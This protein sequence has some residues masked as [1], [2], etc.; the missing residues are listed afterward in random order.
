[1]AKHSLLHR[2]DCHASGIAEQYAAAIKDDNEPVFLCAHHLTR[3]AD[4]LDANGWT[5]VIL[6][7]PLVKVP[8]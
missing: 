8:A 4:W 1:M 5:V 6:N 2:A 3:H 7:A